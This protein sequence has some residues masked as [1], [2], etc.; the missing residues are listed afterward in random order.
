MYRCTTLPLYKVL[1]PIIP[2]CE[3]AYVDFGMTTLW[4]RFRLYPI[5][6]YSAYSSARSLCFSQCRSVQSAYTLTDDSLEVDDEEFAIREPKQNI[7]V[8]EEQSNLEDVSYIGPPIDQRS[9][10]FG[11]FVNHSYVLRKLVDLGVNF[12]KIEKS[13]QKP[14]YL[15]QLNFEADVQPRIQYVHSRI[16]L[17]LFRMKLLVYCLLQVSA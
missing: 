1:H 3:G 9:F 6:T 12:Y 5:N 11:A 16:Y 2:A 4:K 15:I 14:D 17:Q 10:N 13:I 8:L 7:S